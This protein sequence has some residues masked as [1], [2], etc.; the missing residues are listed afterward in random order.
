MGP[1]VNTDRGGAKGLR[2]FCSLL[3]MLVLLWEVSAAHAADVKEVRDLPYGEILFY[4]FQPEYFTALTR[5]SGAIEQERVDNHKDESELLLGG[6]YLSYGMHTDAEAIFRRLLNDNVSESVSNRAW[7]YLAKIFYHRGYLQDSEHALSQVRGTLSGELEG[8]KR[9]LLALVLMRQSRYAEAV[10]V[11][12]DWT[13]PSKWQ[14]Y[15]RYNLGVALVKD[16]MVEEG[17]ALLKEVGTRSAKTDELKALRDKANLALGY[18]LLNSGAQERAK[19]SLQRVRLN[20]PYSG[21][22]LLGVGWADSNLEQFDRALVPWTELQ[23]RDMHEA[24]TRESLLAV[25]YALGKLQAFDQASR[26]YQEATEAYQREIDSLGASIDAIRSGKMVAAILQGV[27]E[28]Q[29]GWF[30]RFEELPDS[31]ETRHLHHLIAQHEFQEALKNYRDLGSLEANLDQWVVSI[32]A[33]EDM[34]TARRQSYYERL[35]RTQER[36]QG[37]DLDHFRSQRDGLRERLQL[38]ERSADSL[39]LASAEEQSQLAQLQHIE[40]RLSELPEGSEVAYVRAKH[41]L[42]RGV[43][44]WDIDK[45]YKARLHEVR[46]GIEQLDEALANSQL[47]Q[48]ALREATMVAPRGF[49][50]YAQRITELNARIARLRPRVSQTI[51]RQGRFLNQLAIAELQHQQQELR[52]YMMQARFALAR[53]YDQSANLSNGQ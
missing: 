34:L 30:S 38:I 20:G 15:A 18:A 24:A 21:K 35:P 43:L 42:L 47:G 41:D 17:V 10:Q 3:L 6:M 32:E 23:S 31:P 40:R 1:R 44:L 4:F 36:L 37:L 39:G 2:R 19:R 52:S 7:F 14:V 45:Q 26:S 48:H 8:E 12:K 22:A 49:E 11:L 28:G 50:G 16:G 53:I 51:A 25:P 29:T 33:Y 46:S 27:S 13:G 5:L 9:F